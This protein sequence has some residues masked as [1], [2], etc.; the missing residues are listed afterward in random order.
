MFMEY[1]DVEALDDDGFVLDEVKVNILDASNPDGDP[2]AAAIRQRAG[3]VRGWLQRK[4]ELPASAL[5]SKIMVEFRFV[6]DSW[7]DFD[8]GGWFIDDVAVLLE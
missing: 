4:I 8:Q 2:L 7:N 5:G 6:S 3:S 1:L